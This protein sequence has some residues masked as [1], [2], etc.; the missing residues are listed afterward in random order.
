MVDTW[1][2]SDDQGWSRICFSFCDSFYSL[3][4]VS[5]H[6]DLCN[7]YV[8]VAHCDRSKVFLLS[9]FSACCELSDSTSLSRLRRL[10][11]CI[12]V[13]F[14]IEYHY[15]DVFST[16]KYVVN[17][18]E[19]DIVSPSVTTED[20]LGFLSEEVFLSKDFFCFVTSASFKS[21]NKFVCSSAVCST[22]SKC[23]QPFLTSCLNVFVCSVSNNV[24]NFCF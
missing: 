10:S 9:F 1:S 6:S 24:F 12:R 18:T 5:T 11:T 21:S 2:V 3:V 22:Y 20:P 17:T 14:C 15:V 16:C 19:S 23:I 13:N 7:V 4:E 8:T